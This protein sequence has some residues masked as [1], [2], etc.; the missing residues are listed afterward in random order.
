M[1]TKL[2][3]IDRIFLAIVVLLTVGGFF[4][5][6]S[7]SL[8]L[9][10]R[11]G[12]Q[13]GSVT[14]NQ[15]LSLCLGAAAFFIASRIK[16]TYWKKYSFYIFIGALL[17]NLLIFIPGLSLTHG[18][19]TRWIDLGFFTFQPSELLKI[20]FIIYCAAWLSSLKDKITTW[21]TG[22]APFILMTGVIGCLLIAQSDTD[23]LVVIL[24]SGLAMFIVA[25]AKWKHIALLILLGLISIS[26]IAY[27]RPYARERIMT[28]INP[29][30]DPLGSGYQIQQS[31]IAIGSGR[32][33][34]RGFG[35]SVQKFNYL[36]EPIGDS[37]FA[38]AAE[39]FGFLG[40]LVIV[41]LFL[42][43]AIHGFKISTKAP[44]VFSGL[45]V[46]GIVIL[47]SVE[48][49]MNISAMLGITPLSGMPLLFVSHGGT[50]L[51]MVL[52]AVGIIA[53]ISR[54]TRT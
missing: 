34:G 53:N 17:V 48:S 9:V 22:L 52:G 38:V 29:A 2:H 42:G 5:F 21:K 14:F 49:F 54:Y 33:T 10:A 20:A 32:I 45:M 31:L 18:G 16:Y 43:L 13:I 28:F 26:M 51:I 39:E 24:T 36:P 27:V 6:S 25:G 1:A 7:A 8:G 30:A 23:T 47:V 3:R 11:D 37:I 50:A 44:D 35:Q 40:S 12:A 15:L 41:G 19:A 4:I 46:I